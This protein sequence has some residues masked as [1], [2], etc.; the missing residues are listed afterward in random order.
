MTF[1]KKVEDFVCEHCATVV[2]GNGFTNHCPK[3]LW[4]KHVDT[5]PGDRAAACGGMMEPVA[6][7]GSTP[8]YR[9]VHKCTLCGKEMRVNTSVEDDPEALLALAR[10]RMP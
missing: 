6:L 7:E 2:H 4:S 8:N 1:I 9:L 10:K 3:C 5:S